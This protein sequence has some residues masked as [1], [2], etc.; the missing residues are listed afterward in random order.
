MTQRAIKQVLTERFYSWRDAQE[1]ARDDP[2]VDMSGEGPAYVPTDF[3][4]EDVI[5]EEER[6]A[7]EAAEGEGPQ[8]QLSIPEVPPEGRPESRPNA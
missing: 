1:V 6:D 2:E 3:V 7:L 8:E 4:E 5:E